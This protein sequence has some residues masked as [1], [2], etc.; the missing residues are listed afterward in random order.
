MDALKTGQLIASLRKERGLSQKAL[1]EKLLVTDKAVSRWET[2]RG[3]PDI[4]MLPGLA[5]CLDVTVD[6]LLRGELCNGVSFGHE[7]EGNCRSGAALAD[8]GL[9]Q[10]GGPRNFLRYVGNSILEVWGQWIFAAGAVMVLGAVLW[11]SGEMALPLAILGGGM[12]CMGRF[13]KLFLRQSGRVRTC[14]LKI[15]ILLLQLAALL[16]EIFSK[17]VIM[18]F[19]AP[20][21]KTEPQYYSYFSHIPLGYGVWGPGVCA[22]MTIGL[23]VCCLFS[24]LRPDSRWMGSWMTGLCVIS[25]LANLSQM[26]LGSGVS[27]VGWTVA[28]LTIFSLICAYGVRYLSDGK[29]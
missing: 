16:L 13:D 20:Y 28:V 29:T 19:A 14:W 1:A 6:E 25:L 26:V 3:M 12:V 11:V 2:G 4:T 17:G 24:L 22:V 8:T 10:S 23:L 5:K 7:E 9:Q 18:R 21:G 27:A 15:I